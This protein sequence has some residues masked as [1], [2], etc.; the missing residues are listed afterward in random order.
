MDERHSVAITNLSYLVLYEE[1]RVDYVTPEKVS[2]V[3]ETSPPSWPHEHTESGYA[4]RFAPA[5]S[6]IMPDDPDA[7]MYVKDDKI[8][9]VVRKCVKRQK[10]DSLNVRVLK[11]LISSS[12]FEMD[13]AALQNLFYAANDIFFS[14]ELVGRVTWDWSDPNSPQYYD[15]VVGT[16]A[17]KRRAASL[18]GGWDTLIVLS[19]PV[20]KNPA[21]DRRLL[22]CAFLHE[23]IHCYLYI[24]C[25]PT[26]GD[27]NGHTDGFKQVAAIMDD[28]VGSDL[29]RLRSLTVEL[30]YFRTDQQDHSRQHSWR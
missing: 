9:G 14:N 2:R 19:T 11:G 26:A 3:T 16:T 20:L 22:I 21:Y 25:G 17:V 12:S 6:L 10:R 29:L 5:S 23:L 28:W 7:N 27:N 18:G 1:E 4:I 13:D 24:K 30:D 15:D 8:A